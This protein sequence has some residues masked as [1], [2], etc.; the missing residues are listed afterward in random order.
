MRL[1]GASLL[2]ER[3]RQPWAADPLQSRDGARRKSRGRSGGGRP[4]VW[5]VRGCGG[6]RRGGGNGEGRPQPP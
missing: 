1:R 2:P 3:L 6:R 5:P 4:Q